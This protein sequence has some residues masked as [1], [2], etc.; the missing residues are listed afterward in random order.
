MSHVSTL[1]VLHCD[2]VN[3]IDFI[4]VEDGADVWV[5]QCGSEARFTFKTFEVC[6]S[7]GKLGGQDFDNQGAA[8]FGIDSFIDSAL[9]ALTELLENLVIALA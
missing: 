3:A 1:D 4:E 2:E 7:G 8:E 6:F 5:V 9:S